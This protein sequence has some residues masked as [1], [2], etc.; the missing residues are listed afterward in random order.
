MPTPG[1]VC[2]QSREWYRAQR[3]SLWVYLRKQTKI[4]EERQAGSSG[5]KEK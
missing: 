2:E 1:T 4:D 3:E 5:R